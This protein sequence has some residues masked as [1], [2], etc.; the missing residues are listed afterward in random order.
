VALHLTVS[1]PSLLLG[2][3]I[4]RKRLKDYSLVNFLVMTSC[5]TLSTSFPGLTAVV[6]IML[7]SHRVDC[8]ELLLNIILPFCGIWQAGSRLS[9]LTGWRS[10]RKAIPPRL[11]ELATC[12]PWRSPVQLALTYTLVIRCVFLPDSFVFECIISHDL[13]S[14]LDVVS[15]CPRS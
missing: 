1:W 2:I 13:L 9:T 10:R 3:L 7:W 15:C 11:T 5:F 14:S 12:Q 4:S 6:G 8:L